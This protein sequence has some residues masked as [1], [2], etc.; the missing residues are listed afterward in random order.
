MLNYT[1]ETIA[2]SWDATKKSVFL[3]LPEGLYS[4]KDQQELVQEGHP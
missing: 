1:S 4:G 3:F 2:I